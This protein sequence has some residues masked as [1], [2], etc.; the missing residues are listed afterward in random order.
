VVVL[1]TFRKRQKLI[2]LHLEIAK[3]FRVDKVLPNPLI[4]GEAGKAVGVKA[5]SNEIIAF[6]DSDN[7]LD[8]KERLRKMVEPFGD[9]EIVGSAP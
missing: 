5:A 1:T 3:T 8:G 6:I 4:T 9:S 7:I 2:C